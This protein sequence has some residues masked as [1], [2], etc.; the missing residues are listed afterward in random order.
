MVKF[1]NDATGVVVSVDDS[2]A[3]R[4]MYGFTRQGASRPASAP[5]SPSAASVSGEPP[6]AGK[7]SGRDAWA[8]FAASKGVEVDDEMGRD[9]I[10]DAVDEA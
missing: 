4:V 10:I 2:K 1:V 7:G 6:R 9:E 8:D 3:D 5:E